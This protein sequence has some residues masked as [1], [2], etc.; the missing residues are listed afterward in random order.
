MK[1]WNMYINWFTWSL[2]ANLLA[3]SWI[4]TSDDIRPELI[5]GL[6]L[7]MM[8]ALGISIVGSIKAQAYFAAV[9]RKG[10]VLLKNMGGETSD[11]ELI[12]GAL[13]SRYVGWSL[14]ATLAAIL[15]GWGLVVIK[16]G[17]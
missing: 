6:G 17:I 16:Y 14:P 2:G 12:F 7:I 10:A 4:I 3:I 15:L 5:T 9:E 13:L 8:F 1:I 11:A